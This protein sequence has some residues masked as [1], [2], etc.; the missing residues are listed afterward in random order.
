MYAQETDS[1]L[2]PSTRFTGRL[3]AVESSRILPT[4]RTFFGH[5]KIVNVVEGSVTVETAQGISTLT[6]GM[7]LALGEARWCRLRP[8]PDV[9]TWTIYADDEF[10][11][12]VMAWFL[13]DRS[14]VQAGLHPDE[15]DGRAIVITPGLLAFQQA[16][17][18]WRQMSLLQDSIRTPET[19]AAQTIELFARW[20]DIVSP[21]LLTP[22]LV[23]N[24]T[25]EVESP[26]RG[27]LAGS[28]MT[29]HVGR[30][31]RLLRTRMN[32]QWTVGTLAG[33]VALSR[34][35]LTR[36]FTRQF[37]ASPMRFLNEVRLTEF[38]RLIEETDFSVARAA[39]TVGWSDPRVASAWFYRRFGIRPSQYRLKP[40][41][42][43][44]SVDGCDGGCSG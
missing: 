5:A 14:R 29:G 24:P 20:I 6:A 43:C 3:Y 17:P 38:T 41:P 18:L 1:V 36:L 44:P 26:I 19:V 23:A 22:G 28:P 15:W 40:H 12:T 2:A 10:L 21:A 34:S 42:H 35:H 8:V 32:E 39:N 9:R 37:G 33:E 7:S 11:R 4:N 27:R 16:E 30:A 13:P 25:R 31:A